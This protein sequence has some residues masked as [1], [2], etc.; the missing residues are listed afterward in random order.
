M[1][2]LVELD[3]VGVRRPTALILRDV[4]LS[5]E[6]GSA[7]AVFG[8][9]GSGKTTL[10]RVVAT[11]TAPTSGRGSVLGR[12]LGSPT[13]EQIRPRIGLVGHQHALF[14]MLTLAEN[15]RLVA[16]LAGEDDAPATARRTLEAVGLGDAADR[17]AADCSNGMRRRAEFARLLITRPS[18]LLLDEAHVGLDPSAAALVDLLVST[19]LESGGAAVVVSHERER[20]AAITSRRLALEGGILVEAS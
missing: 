16:R 8:A 1:P 7:V 18:L 2:P 10:L 12:P 20:A 11:L 19:T 15:L 3:G 5:I 17:L 9:N 14:E 4:S 13:V 6:P